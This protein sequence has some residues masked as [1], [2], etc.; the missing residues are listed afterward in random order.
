MESEAPPVYQTNLE[1]NEIRTSMNKIIYQK[2]K[3]LLDN[4]DNLDETG[5][6]DTHSNYIRWLMNGFDK[7][8]L[9]KGFDEDY[10]YVLNKLSLRYTL[11]NSYALRSINE[12]FEIKN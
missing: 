9:Y 10:D 7:N 1:Q 11:Y 12:P 5:I 4:I 8:N 3:D 6:T 2:L